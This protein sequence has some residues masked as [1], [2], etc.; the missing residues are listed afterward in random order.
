MRLKSEVKKIPS[1]FVLFLF[2]LNPFLGKAKFSF[3]VTSDQRKY[4]GPGKYDS[5]EYFW[6]AVKAIQT[7]GKGAFMISPGD[8]DPPE[9][10]KWTIEQI[11][12]LNYPW[13]PVVGNHELP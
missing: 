11:L 6:G 5:P 8:I 4:S 13:Y 9:N 2:L 1:L 10:S 7:Q 3:V 12:G